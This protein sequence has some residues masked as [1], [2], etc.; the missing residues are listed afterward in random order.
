MH[1]LPS[2]IAAIEFGIFAL[3]EREGLSKDQ[4]FQ[5]AKLGK[6]GGDALLCVLCATGYLKKFQQKYYLS[7]A[8]RHFLLESSQNNWL[9][10]LTQDSEGVKKMID[11]L[12]KD[13]DDC[14][15]PSVSMESW[16]SGQISLEDGRRISA[17]M[18]SHSLSAAIALAEIVEFTKFGVNRILDVGGGSGCFSIAIS[19]K[20]PQVHCTVLELADVHKVAQEYINSAGVDNVDAV[21]GNMF[22][23]P[24]P[25]GY[26]GVFYSNILHDWNDEKCK[27]ILKKSFDCLSK[28]GYIFI[29]EALLN[30]DES[31]PLFNCFFSM[32]MF[33]NTEGAQFTMTKLQVMLE[34]AGFSNVGIIPTHK[35]YSVVY[36]RK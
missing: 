13:Y 10:F 16:I 31:G 9:P 32:H 15:K 29:H 23:I 8:S 1:E 19:K 17:F 28:G 27:I 7:D 5:S 35:M 12:R 3:L 34:E 26:N 22:S 36:A 2:L 33:L 11:A 14:K 20:Q 30:E 18:H 4:I 6:R 21:A 25:T 24:F